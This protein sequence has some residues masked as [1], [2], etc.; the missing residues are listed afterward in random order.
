MLFRSGLAYA[1][2][3][4]CG[5]R[6]GPVFPAVFIGVALATLPVIAFDISPTVAVAAGAAAGMAAGTRLLI[7]PILFGALLVGHA[8]LDAIPAAVLAAAAAWITVSALDALWG[9]REQ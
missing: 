3:M 6:G 8:G 9:E 2:C 5:F 4:G 7:A 1:I